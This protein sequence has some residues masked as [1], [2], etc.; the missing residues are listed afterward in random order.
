M[1]QN[2]LPK[3]I[4]QIGQTV[5]EPKI[6]IEDY[7]ITFARKLAEKNK[8]GKGMAVLLGTESQKNGKVPVFIKGAV[9]ISRWEEAKGISFDNEIWSDIYEGVKNYFPDLEIVGWLYLHSGQEAGFDEKIKFI[10]ET[11]FMGSGDILFVFDKEEKEESFYRFENSHFEKQSG[12]YIYYEKNEPMQNYMIDIFGN[13]SQEQAGEDK[14]M[15][16]VR[17][18]VSNKEVNHDKKTVNFAYVASTALAAVVLVMGVAT[19]NNYDKMESMEKTLNRISANIEA[20]ENQAGIEGQEKT[21]LVVETITGTVEGK[22]VKVEAEELTENISEDEIEGLTENANEEQ[23]ATDEEQKLIEETM[24]DSNYYI[25][26][27]G[28]TL[29][30]ISG[31]VYGSDEYVDEIQEI[32]QIENKDMIYEG[33]KL[34]MP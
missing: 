31:A 20:K 32:N 25:V 10:H 11:N 28:D 1:E 5:K 24:S 27:K 4:R 2:Q 14:V 3:N 8:D 19:L 22:Q 15:E 6:Y 23:Q 7:V 17:E 12:Y 16:Q 9:E 29:V 18:L 33:Q 26:K 30:S 21:E 13:K 34:V